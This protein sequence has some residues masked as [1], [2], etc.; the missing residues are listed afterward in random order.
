MSPAHVESVATILEGYAQRG[1]FRGF[2]RG[3]RRGGTT[4]FRIVW[5]RNRDFDLGVDVTKRTLRFANVLPNIPAR[6]A[7]YKELKQ[8]IESRQGE[9]L[10]EHRRIDR[11]RAEVHA[12]N[13]N[14]SV[15]LTLEVHDGDFETA[16]RKFV[17]LL[18]EI[19]MTFLLDGNY[20]EYMVESFDL[21]PDRM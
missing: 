6:S 14:G 4:H 17:H 12:S 21:D 13:R 16:T 19:F 15:S 10:P 20:F 5:H 7:M 2:S 3:G 8:F 11:R 1:V 9:A 18:H